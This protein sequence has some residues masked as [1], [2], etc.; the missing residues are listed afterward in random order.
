MVIRNTHF[1]GTN[2]KFEKNY[3]LRQGQYKNEFFSQSLA[4]KLAFFDEYDNFSKFLPRDRQLMIRLIPNVAI[5]EWT[6]DRLENHQY[7]HIMR[8]I[9]STVSEMCGS[10]EDLF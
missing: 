6:N 4:F 8:E 2:Y 1:L 5:E 7:D 10:I 3:F 9:Q